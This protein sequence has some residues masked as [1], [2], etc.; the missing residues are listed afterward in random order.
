MVIAGWRSGE[1]SRICDGRKRGGHFE[2]IV[3]RSTKVL[4]C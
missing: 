2:L 3:A 1:G 4:H